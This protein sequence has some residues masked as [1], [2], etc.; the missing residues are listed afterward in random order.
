MYRHDGQ[1]IFVIDGHAH[2]WDARPENWRNKYGESWIKCFFAYHNAL[3]PTEE[4]W[5][6]EKFCH[7]GE[8]KIVEDL[9][10]SLYNAPEFSWNH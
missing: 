2:F 8:Q 9:V 6:F 1:D 10:W 5:P 3:G 4:A 7:Y